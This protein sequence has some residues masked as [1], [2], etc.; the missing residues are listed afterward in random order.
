M[1]LFYDFQ[2]HSMKQ[3]LV[4]RFIQEGRD[5]SSVCYS[6]L[7]MLQQKSEAF[8]QTSHN[9]GRTK[10]TID[11]S[12]VESRS[13]QGDAPKVSWV[14][15]EQCLHHRKGQIPT[16]SL[17]RHIGKREREET[18]GE[19][20]VT[21]PQNK[22]PVV[23]PVKTKPNQTSKQQKRLGGGGGQERKKTKKDNR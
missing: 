11:T 17:K 18:E 2:A 13:N 1:T 3:H 23:M 21:S 8:F 5:L 6:Y 4:V 15:R 10:K 22:L 20:K 14:G 7:L 12:N 19:H 9:S 16:T